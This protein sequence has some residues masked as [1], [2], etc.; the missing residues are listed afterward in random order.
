[1]N[2]KAMWLRWFPMVHLAVYLE[3]RGQQKVT[4]ENVHT[5]YYLKEAL[6]LCNAVIAQPSAP[7]NYVN[8]A[9]SIASRIQNK[10]LSITNEQ[11]I[12]PNA[13]WL[14]A[15]NYRNLNEVFLTIAKI[16]YEDYLDI[17]ENNERE[18]QIELI[19]SKAM[20][21][22]LNIRF[23]LN[24]EGDYRQHALEVALP[25]LSTGFYVIIA[26]PQKQIIYNNTNI[27]INPVW[28]SNIAWA[29]RTLPDGGSEFRFSDRKSGRAL[30]GVEVTIYNQQYNQYKQRA[31]INKGGEYKADS[32]G[33]LSIPETGSQ[34][35]YRVKLKSQNEEV[36][37][38]QSFYQYPESKADKPY[39]QTHYF[40]DRKV[41]GR[42]KLYILKAL[43][44]NIRE[45]IVS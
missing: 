32:E 41:I 5:R 17:L 44:S 22:D 19:S 9:S 30:P 6:D 14:A 11:I 38:E 28:V 15:I 18:K 3:S 31:T 40:T 26:A 10:Q 21:R 27:C 23:E 43:Q 37:P 1:M 16:D 20:V 24:D 12:L 29:Q 8:W 35:R 39:V 4:A 34:Q 42:V 2:T 36:W 7:S 13:E 25:P 45:K 33:F